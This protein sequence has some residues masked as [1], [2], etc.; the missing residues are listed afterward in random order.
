MKPLSIEFI[1]LFQV[2]V[3]LYSVSDF[4]H[5][6]GLPAQ[7]IAVR[8]LSK[9]RAR[10][11]HDIALGLHLTSILIKSGILH[12]IEKYNGQYTFSPQKFFTANGDYRN[13]LPQK[14][15]YRE[16]NFLL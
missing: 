8:M 7:L 2:I 12:C 4:N 14:I 16:N 1:R 3:S 15:F 5:S 13:F 9:I 11:I 10:S 6:L